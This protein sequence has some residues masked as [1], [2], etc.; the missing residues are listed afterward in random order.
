MPSQNPTHTITDTLRTRVDTFAA[1]CCDRDLLR[2]QLSDGNVVLLDTADAWVLEKYRLR[3]RANSRAVTAIARN[4]TR[5][6]VQLARLLLEPGPG[7]VVDHV[8]GDFLD[9]RR[10]NLRI[11]TM[12][13][14]TQN[15]AKQAR[16]SSRFK[17]V[18]RRRNGW[19]ACIYADGKTKHLGDFAEEADAA[20]AYDDA[21]RIRFGDFAALNF[22]RDGE[23]G[24]LRRNVA[25]PIQIVGGGNLPTTDD[26]RRVSHTPHPV[27]L[28]EQQFQA[29]SKPSHDP[30]SKD[31]ERL[32]MVPS[33]LAGGTGGAA[34]DQAFHGDAPC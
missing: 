12:R 22:P 32:A 24:C 2:H 5:F 20:R 10:H 8:N 21:A 25:P 1:A 23:V 16:T 19:M 15:K 17:G 34:G 4:K 6:K 31:A 14:N 18:C 9:N 33:G 27:G 30:L 13:Q 29:L 7:F 28:G 11:A 26:A 3:V